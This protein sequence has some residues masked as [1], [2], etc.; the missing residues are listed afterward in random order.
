MKK[1]FARLNIVH[2]IDSG[3]VEWFAPT[4][5][6]QEGEDILLRRI[7]YGKKNGFYV[8]IGA[9]H[10]KRFSNTYLFYKMKWR[11]INVDAMPGS[12]TKFDS[13]RPRDI[14]IE[15]AVSTSGDRV[16]FFVFNDTALNTCIESVA[17]ER[18]GGRYFIKEEI[19]VPS[20]HL[21]EILDEH[22]PP[23]QHIDFLSVDVEGKDLEVLQSNDWEKY[24]PTVILIE[25]ME[26]S[27]GVELTND[28]IYRF[29]TG[30]GY[31]FFGKTVYTIVFM[32]KEHRI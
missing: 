19:T 18:V 12:M 28:S 21:S 14:N 30:K 22:L 11:G 7:F 27:R 13:V 9:H 8:D 29:L 3:I 24:R 20:K 5:Y 10:P 16:K 15:C 2:H 4:S 23:A 17:R 32:D 26:V 6:S 25:T 31:E 1:L